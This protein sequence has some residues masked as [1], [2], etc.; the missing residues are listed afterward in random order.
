MQHGQITGTAPA[1][2]VRA[3]WRVGTSTCIAQVLGRPGV[4]ASANKQLAALGH[5]M[6][7]FIVAV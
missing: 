5:T 1:V 7:Y 2:L 4:N 3:L 6:L